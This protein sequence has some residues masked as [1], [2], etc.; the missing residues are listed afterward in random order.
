MQT[1]DNSGFTL[2]ELMIVLAIIGILAAVAMPNYNDYI[3]RGRITEAVAS[4][5]DARVRMEQFFQ[6]NRFYNTDGG[7]GTGCAATVTL[8]NTTNFQFVCVAGNNGQ[9]YT[10]T[11][12]GLSNM[13][14]FHYTITQTN[15][16][17]TTI[18]AN[19]AWPAANANCWVTNKSGAC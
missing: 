5:S 1:R 14:G 9:T 8:A 3:T 10:W 7:A 6:D 13:T 4:L 15:A 12:N 17:A 19:S 11:A 18:D 2:I 16:R